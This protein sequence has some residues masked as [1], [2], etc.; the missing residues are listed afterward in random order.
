MI[1][2]SLTYFVHSS[3]WYKLS[4]L[5][6]EAL[7]CIYSL[8][9]LKTVWY[10]SSCCLELDPP[11]F[12]LFNNNTLFPLFPLL[13]KLC[14]RECRRQAHT[15]C[16]YC[17]KCLPNVIWSCCFIF[18]FKILWSLLL[19]FQNNRYINMLVVPFKCLFWIHELPYWVQ[20]R[21]VSSI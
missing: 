15:F 6:Y 17:L 14:L 5:S 1:F 21:S 4:S 9:V 13:F 20:K 19:L 18:F 11:L 3:R 10:L 2:T 16:L 8:R 12:V 7:S